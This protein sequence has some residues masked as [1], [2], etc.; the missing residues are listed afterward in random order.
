MQENEDNTGSEKVLVLP[1]AEG[2]KKITQVLSND[3]AMKILDILAD[4]PMSAS[5]VAEK[6]GMPLTTIKYNIDALVEADL[7][8]VKKTKWSKKGREIKI[9]EPVQKI[10][11]VAP[12]SV[13]G[14][15]SSIL[16]MLKKYLIMVG[17]AIFAATGLEALT[18]YLNLGIGTSPMASSVRSTEYQDT[19]APLLNEDLPPEAADEAFVPEAPMEEK[20][21]PESEEM[22]ASDV[23]GEEVQE[24][25]T[26]EEPVTDQAVDG[27]DYEI[28]ESPTSD[29]MLVPEDVD[30][31]AVSSVIP[32]DSLDNGA[33]ILN[34]NL[35]PANQVP[36]AG[37]SGMAADSVSPMSHQLSGIIPDDLL[38][39]A[40]VWFFFGCLFVIALLFIREIYYRNKEI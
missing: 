11:V 36:A 34:E 7:I 9:Y 19:V 29:D 26:F 33:N 27:Q 37:D 39:H 17:G 38:S 15:K 20:A 35:S 22:S 32:N 40:S 24:A 10:I 16:S 3:R 25:E 23:T 30:P 12:G 13:K 18:N 31:E 8:K 21:V 5:D 1:L 4:T 2:S 6:T 14:D 28:T